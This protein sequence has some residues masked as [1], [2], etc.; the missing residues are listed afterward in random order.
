MPVLEAAPPALDPY[1]Y[2]V[3]AIDAAGNES[4]PSDSRTIS[5]DLRSTENPTLLDAPSPT[6]TAPSLRWTFL[7]AAARYRV[8]RDGVAVGETTATTFSDAALAVDGAHAYVVVALRADGSELGRSTPRT[9]VHDTAAPPAPTGVTAPA[10]VNRPPT[11]SWDAGAEA[12][13]YRVYRDGTP[14]GETTADLADGRAHSPP[15][16][17]TRTR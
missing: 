17:P 6:R 1:T 4:P 8:L 16:A 9:V 3:V 2:R 10:H 15:R 5:V 13:S 14:V 7:A 12:A 11:V